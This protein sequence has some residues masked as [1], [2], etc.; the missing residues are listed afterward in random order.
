MDSTHGTCRA[1]STVPITW[2][3]SASCTPSTARAKDEPP[4]YS[5]GADKT[6]DLGGCDSVQLWSLLEEADRLGLKL[7]HAHP[8][9][10]EVRY[11]QRGELLIDVTRGDDRGSLVSAVLQVDGEDMDDL[12]PLL[13]LGSSGH[14][15]VC[16]E[17]DHGETGADAIDGPERRRLRLVRLVKPAPAAL[18]R[19]VLGGERLSIPTGEL[20]RFAE[21]LYPALRNVATVVSSD[22]SFT[23]PEISAPALV[24]RA[25]YGAGHDVEVGWEWAYR[26]GDATRHAALRQQRGRPRVSR[27]RRRARDPR[28]R[29]PHRHGPRALR[30]ARRR[31]ASRRPARGPGPTHGHRQHAPDD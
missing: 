24:L 14:G 4:T 12:E 28:E 30:P 21:E 5:Y 15:L 19:M 25:S 13:F 20:Q 29:R 17:R 3:W 11:H 23:P 9:L 1:A 31:R 27:P 16:A 8:G 26:I 2:R 7:I 18:Q 10:G 6:L 22:G